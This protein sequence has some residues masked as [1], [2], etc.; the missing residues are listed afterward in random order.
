MGI[1]TLLL[2]V[3]NLFDAAGTLYGIH[4]GYAYE[5]NPIMRYALGVG[6]AFF[7]SLKMALVGLPCLFLYRLR[8]K[9]PRLALYLVV[10]VD[11]VYV[12]VACVHVYGFI[13][14]AR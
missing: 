1:A 4:S 10:G 9:A 8:H 11:V 7:L 6:D 14:F 13:H 3:L 5:V 12:G 2:F